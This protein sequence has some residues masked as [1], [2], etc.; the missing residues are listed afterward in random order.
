MKA[1]AFLGLL[2]FV[3]CQ[4]ENSPECQSGW[5]RCNGV[6]VQ[7]CNPN[8][9]RWRNAINCLEAGYDDCAEVTVRYTESDVS[10]P[11][12]RGDETEYRRCVTEDTR[13]DVWVNDW[14]CIDRGQPGQG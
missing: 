9:L 7:T 4:G 1:A 14:I 6:T 5:K 10:A 11:L 13:K 8:T 12:C 3:A 2:W